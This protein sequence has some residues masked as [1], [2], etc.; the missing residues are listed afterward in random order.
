MARLVDTDGSNGIAADNKV[1]IVGRTN[2]STTA[3][4]A[5]VA[6]KHNKEHG[7]TTKIGIDTDYSSADDLTIFRRRSEGSNSNADLNTKYFMGSKGLVR[8]GG[9]GGNVKAFKSYTKGKA[10]FKNAADST[11]LALSAHGQLLY[12]DGGAIKARDFPVTMSTNVVRK[13]TAA[14]N[15]PNADTAPGLNSYND[16]VTYYTKINPS[17]TVTTQQLSLSTS[18]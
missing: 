5:T 16:T 6:V 17:A 12:V 8:S 2:S 10:I 7:Y 4:T 14:A 9:T 3:D 13:T 18:K 15:G 1:L 11:A